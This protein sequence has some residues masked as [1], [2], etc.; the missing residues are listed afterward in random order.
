M[1]RRR[2]TIGATAV[3][4]AVCFV[5]AVPTSGADF[6]TSGQGTVVIS[7]EIPQKPELPVIEETPVEPMFVVEPAP[8]PTQDT[9]QVL[10]AEETP[11]PEP[12]STTLVEEVVTSETVSE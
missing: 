6:T 2:S 3:L 7:F 10:P 5:C 9:G 8:M 4:L 1:Q 11:L 12:V